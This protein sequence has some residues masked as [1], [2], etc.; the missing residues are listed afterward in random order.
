MFF[1]VAFGMVRHFGRQIGFFEFDWVERLHAY[2]YT[3]VV[4]GVAL[5]VPAD[6]WNI[7]IE[8]DRLA[9]EDGPVVAVVAKH[10][11]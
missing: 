2:A 6:V 1:P 7:H 11:E 9:P 8:V 5:C 4:I 3:L 10:A